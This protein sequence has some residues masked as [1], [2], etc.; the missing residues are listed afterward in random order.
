MLGYHCNLCYNIR[1]KNVFI[2]LN[3]CWSIDVFIIIA[4]IEYHVD[5][6]GV[7]DKEPIQPKIQI[8]I[9]WGHPD[10]W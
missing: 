9:M 6:A 4:I 3:D 7:L 1:R 5:I 10:I 8:G 2:V